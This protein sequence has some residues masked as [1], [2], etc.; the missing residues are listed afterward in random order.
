MQPMFM[1]GDIKRRTRLLVVHRFLRGLQR[2]HHFPPE[3]EGIN[4]KSLIYIAINGFYFV[5]IIIFSMAKDT[6]VR[7]S[8]ERD[9]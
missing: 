6:V 8:N 2:R 5:L 3:N 7:L 1:G 4:R 9:S